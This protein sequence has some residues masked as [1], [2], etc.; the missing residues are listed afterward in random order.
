MNEAMHRARGR[1]GRWFCLGLLLLLVSCG[2]PPLLRDVRV[3][4]ALIQPNA[5]GVNDLATFSFLLTRNATVS[6][7]LIDAAGQRYTFRPPSRLSVR[8]TAYTVLFPGVVDG[9]TLPG[10]AY[11]FTILKRMLPDGVYTWEVAAVA[12]DGE[13]AVVTGTLTLRDADTRLPAIRD[14][15]I[16]PREIAPNQDGI[17][18]VAEVTLWLDKDVD[19]L[20]VYLRRPDGG[21]Q[22]LIHT[23]GEVEPNRA[24]QHRFV[25]DTRFV[26]G[27]P[28]PDGIH[29]L[30]V[31]ARDRTGQ[32]VMLTDTLSLRHSGIPR[33]YVVNDEV[34][35][36]S[37]TLVL[38]ETLCFTL[39]VQNDSATYL[40]TGAP[41]SGAEYRG[42]VSYI[43][44]GWPEDPGIF[45][46]GVD[47]DTSLRSFPYRWGLGQPGR[48]LV[49]I[50]GHWYLPPHARAQ[51]TGCVQVVDVPT[52]NPLYFWIGLLHEGMVTPP[53]NT[54]I[55]PNF[56]TIWSP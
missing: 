31:E 8:E 27:E 11:P 53:R 7:T 16:V 45:R 12:D 29:P 36:S 38:S 56:V 50:D 15:T 21:T 46:V 18:D 25:Y 52:R 3:T 42:D 20:S 9:Y 43:E 47:F 54:R 2:R 13:R 28:P 34:D 30:V 22:A 6:I 17:D 55:S 5:D 32:H 40:R 49:E 48:E 10:E 39:T 37:N 35:W 26:V 23:P 1:L 44:A 19:A 33:A 4:P 24:G 41:W 14:L 51:V